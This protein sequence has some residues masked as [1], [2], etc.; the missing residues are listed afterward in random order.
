MQA[1]NASP[2]IAAILAT[3][4]LDL[5]VD[6]VLGLCGIAF[7]LVQMGYLLW[8]WRRDWKRDRDR[9]A[10]GLPPPDTDRGHL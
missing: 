2:S 8:K 7:I 4:V 3:K 10:A 9:R 1:L 6:T 5:S